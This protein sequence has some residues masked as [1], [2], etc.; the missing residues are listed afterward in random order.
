MHLS[1][2][3]TE[4]QVIGSG[5]TSTLWPMG[6]FLPKHVFWLMYSVQM[7][8][9]Q[10]CMRNLWSHSRLMMGLERKLLCVGEWSTRMI[11]AAVI[12]RTAQ[13]RRQ[14]Q[15]RVRMID[16][17]LKVNL[18][19]PY[20]NIQSSGNSQSKKIFVYCFGLSVNLT[21]YFTS[22]KWSSSSLT[23]WERLVMSGAGSKEGSSGSKKPGSRYLEKFCQ[24]LAMTH[25]VLGEVLDKTL[26]ALSMWGTGS[27]IC[28]DGV[29]SLGIS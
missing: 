28:S 18:N 19:T 29:T 16:Q 20:V 4:E 14:V 21:V 11:A 23:Q 12:R 3:E 6:V 22:L 2:I 5:H 17:N 10:D 26:I 27:F 25:L 7:R 8:M 1:Q 15:A 9:L 13:V 24:W